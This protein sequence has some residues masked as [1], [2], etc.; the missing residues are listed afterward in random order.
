MHHSKN[1]KNKTKDVA[2]ELLG[3]SYYQ[4]P[5]PRYPGQ[6]YVPPA[7]YPVFSP[8]SGYPTSVPT[9]ASLMQDNDATVAHVGYGPFRASG[10]SKRERGDRYDPEVGELLAVS[11]AFHKL[12][13]RMER[14]ANGL[15]KQAFNEQNT[16]HKPLA[17][18]HEELE[19]RDAAELEQAANELGGVLV[20]TYDSLDG[21]VEALRQY[22]GGEE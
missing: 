8:P 16:V 6:Q 17:Q 10:S 9:S 5:P 2:R 11:R 14:R 1:R 19:Q 13:A 15:I 7:S 12:A 3:D 18:W 21:V 20:G 4:A 22:L